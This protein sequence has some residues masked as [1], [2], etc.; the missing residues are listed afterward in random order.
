MNTPLVA[1]PNR[2]V[3]QL[4][5]LRVATIVALV[6]GGLALSYLQAVNIGF[7]PI[8]SGIVVLAL[9]FAGLVASG[10]RWTPLLGTLQ[11][12]TLRFHSQQAPGATLVRT[13]ARHAG[14]TLSGG[15]S[16]VCDRRR[17]RYHR[18]ERRGAGTAPRAH[19]AAKRVRP[20]GATGQSGRDGSPPAGKWRR[21][22]P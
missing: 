9:I 14:R 18:S 7:D 4:G 19:G 3:K 21:R 5:A 6:G 13:G 2:S 15:N 17:L 11:S 8:L 20:Y 12:Q 10:R 16:G 22:G 1:T